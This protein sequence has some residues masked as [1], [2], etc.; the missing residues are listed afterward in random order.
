MISKTIGCRVHYFQTNPSVNWD[1]Y[2][3]FISMYFVDE[4]FSMHHGAFFHVLR[5][6]GFAHGEQ[7]IFAGSS[8][9]RSQ[10]RGYDRLAVPVAW[11][12]AEGYSCSFYVFFWLTKLYSK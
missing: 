12:V 3:D 2:D 5:S 10:S 11:L 8:L 9:S 7:P 1:D 6:P 4:I